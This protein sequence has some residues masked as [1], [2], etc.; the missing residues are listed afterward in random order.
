MD[1]AEINKSLLALKECIRAMDQ[2]LDHTPFRGSKLTQVLKDSFVGSNCRTVM[3]ANVSPCSSAVEH[4]LNTLRYAYRVKELRSGSKAPDKSGDLG[5]MPDYQP[6]GTGQAD[7]AIEEEDGRHEEQLSAD[8]GLEP[9]G[10]EALP[11][12]QQQLRVANL[13][14]AAQSLASPREDGHHGG[15]AAQHSGFHHPSR[16]E[17]DGAT[18]SRSFE[19]RSGSLR[20]HPEEAGASSRCSPLG[21]SDNSH[22]RP[23]S[24]SG[25]GL[26]ASTGG[27]GV[28]QPAPEVHGSELGAHAAA[29]LAGRRGGLPQQAQSSEQTNDHLAPEVALEPVG[30]GCSQA[31]L[32]ELAR[33]HD[34]LIGTILAEEEELITSHRQHI[35]MMVEL[36]KEEMVHLNNVDRPGSDVDA[37]VAGL[38]RILRL[39]A[40]YIGD[41]RSRVDLFKEHLQQEDTLSRKFQSLASSS[42]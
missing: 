2:Q 8:E 32:D 17:D 13:S 24:P 27:A 7:L 25:L 19:S 12:V 11:S 31:A 4:S 34:R 9:G 21:G 41:I 26:S 36:I 20:A 1:G 30:S 33:Q 40:Q 5:G 3:I 10:D 39:K 28:G 22:A 14:A 29:R 15:R 42:S 37:Y 18:A 16:G 6:S 23:T 35:D 38:D